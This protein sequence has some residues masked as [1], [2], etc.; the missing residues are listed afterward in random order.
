MERYQLNMEKYKSYLY[1]A[2]KPQLLVYG[3]N[4]EELQSLEKELVIK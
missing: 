3:M 4:E 1:N 2:I